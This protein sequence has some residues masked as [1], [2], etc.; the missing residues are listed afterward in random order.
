MTRFYDIEDDEGACERF[1]Q[2]ARDG[3]FNNEQALKMFGQYVIQ[4]MINYNTVWQDRLMLWLDDTNESV[5]RLAGHGT[6]KLG[7]DKPKF[8]LK[9]CHGLMQHDNMKVKM[10]AASIL[11]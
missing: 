9:V 10:S 6:I 1:R 2:W 3:V 8:A 5:L 4:K 11:R 7:V